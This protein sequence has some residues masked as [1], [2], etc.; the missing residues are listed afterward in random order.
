MKKL[1]TL[2]ALALIIGLGTTYAQTP[3]ELARQQRELN[4]LNRRLLEAKPTKEAKK[5]AKRLKKAGWEAPAG[6]RSIEQQI[7]EGQLLSAELMADADGSPSRR[8]I[9]HT[10]VATAGTY[11]AAYATARANIQAEVAAMLETELAAAIQQ[12]LDNA[13]DDAQLAVSVDKF[14]QRMRSIV[15]ASLTGAI[16]VVSIYR[17]LPNRNIE[18]QVRLAYDKKAVANKI[19]S[20][21]RQELEAEGDQL[22]DLA[23]KA[24]QKMM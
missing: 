6:E 18:V 1:I 10:A 23:D 13:Q 20:Q 9:Q 11:N 7:T 21:M 24:L 5:E 12:K 22:N 19:R 14:N 4:D 17:T 16:P 2:I 8:Y 15:N 3:A